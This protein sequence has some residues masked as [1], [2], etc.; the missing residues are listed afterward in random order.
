MKKIIIVSVLFI[1]IIKPS[2]AQWQQTDFPYNGKV[3]CIAESNG[4]MFAGTDG[5]GAYLSVNEGSSWT[6]ANLGLTNH[7][8]YSLV[9]SGDNVFAGTDQGVFLSADTG[10]SWT[11]ASF[12]LMQLQVISLASIGS[13]IFAGTWGSGIFYTDNNGSQWIQ[14]NMAGNEVSSFAY[15]DAKIYAGTKNN[16]VFVSTD[17]GINWSM[18]DN[19]LTS[20]FVRS[21]AV[22]GPAIY[23]GTDGGGVFR[24]ETSSISWTAV[25]QGLTIPYIRPLAV[26]GT[27]IYAGTHGIFRSM[28][29]G[30]KWAGVNKCLPAMDVY[31]LVPVGMNLF[32]GTEFGV[33]KCSMADMVDDIEICLVGVDSTNHNMIVWNKTYSPAVDSINIYRETSVT[34]VYEKIGV[35]SNEEQGIF[36]DTASKPKIRSNRY[37]L[38]FNENC[39]LEL[40]QSPPHKTMHLNINQ[41]IGTT[42][43]LIWE[44]YE[45]FSV[46]TYNVYRG[47]SPDDL[48]LIGSS[49]GSNT[50]YSDYSAPTG[51]IYYQV[52]IISP[53]DCS[54]AK[55]MS[56]SRSNVVT[57][58]V[59]EIGDNEM[60]STVFAVYPNPVKD[61]LSIVGHESNSKVC[62]VN[63]YTVHGEKV[64][65]GR[66]SAQDIMN[67]DASMLARGIYFIFVQTDTCTTAGKFIKE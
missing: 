16:Y 61:I 8:V 30:T 48:Q 22:M 25:N 45:G 55:S 66:F 36:V 4:I 10:T 46:S 40:T 51:D 34:N 15:T 26:D 63:I 58:K 32:A 7:N 52:E 56:S 67:I 42:W 33:W 62:D 64:M 59:S 1:C 5:G 29:S 9:F 57:N 39:G 49:S 47:T 2:N 13:R 23:A 60:G 65:N 19:G 44:P 24:C 17:G 14:S 43:N 20:P 12:G 3:L 53:Y 54:P 21:L 18:I 41:G 50:S 6:E 27:T 38:S 31:E 11:P 35:V 28:D 37:K